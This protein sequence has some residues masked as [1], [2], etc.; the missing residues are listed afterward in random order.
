MGFTSMRGKNNVVWHPSENHTGDMY[1]VQMMSYRL[2][3]KGTCR[4]LSLIINEDS[5]I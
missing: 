4:H 3:N 2:Q 1:S 5:T